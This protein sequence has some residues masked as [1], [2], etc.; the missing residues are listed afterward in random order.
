MSSSSVNIDTALNMNNQ[1]NPDIVLE[2]KEFKNNVGNRYITNMSN[3]GI[4]L[5]NKRQIN[6]QQTNTQFTQNL[7]KKEKIIQYLSKYCGEVDLKKYSYFTDDLPTTLPTVADLFIYHYLMGGTLGEICNTH[8]LKNVCNVYKF[9]CK[10]KNSC[11]YYKMI[12]KTNTVEDKERFHGCDEGLWKDYDF[13]NN[14]TSR[15]VENWRKQV[16]KY[17]R[18]FG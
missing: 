8:K 10:N 3:K 15:I 12:S 1:D 2:E 9:L 17:G 7:I 6:R 18:Y 16:K 13:D 11:I 4:N 14:G 5:A